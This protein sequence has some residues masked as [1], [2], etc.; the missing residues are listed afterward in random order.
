MRER[1]V[2]WASDGIGIGIGFRWL[3]VHRS[4][5]TISGSGCH[6]HSNQRSR[7]KFK[8][9]DGKKTTGPVER[10]RQFSFSVCIF[11]P[12]DTRSRDS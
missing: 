12:Q 5:R 6:R 3:N 10:Q 2:I 9:I 8:A 1:A 7:S 11:S 4:G